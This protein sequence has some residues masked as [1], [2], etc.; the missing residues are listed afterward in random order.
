MHRRSTVLR[1]RLEAPEGGQ[2]ALSLEHAFYGL[3]AQRPDQLVLK[4]GD[5]RKE[6]ER[7]KALVGSDRD[8]RASECATN[9]PLVGRVVHAAKPGAWVYAQELNEQT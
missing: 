9:V 2:L 6:T 1:H 7:F 8:S 5:A 4:I 3:D